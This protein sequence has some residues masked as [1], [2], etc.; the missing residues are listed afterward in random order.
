[1]RWS[2]IVIAVVLAVGCSSS[3]SLPA[4]AP[5]PQVGV[6]QFTGEW[7]GSYRGQTFKRDGPLSIV[8][9]TADSTAGVADKVPIQG[10]VRFGGVPRDTR[11]GA[12]PLSAEERRNAH[13]QTVPIDSARLTA[14]GIVMW[15]QSYF[16]SGCNCTISLTTRAVLRGDTLAGTFSAA[17]GPTRVSER[18]R[19]RAVRQRSP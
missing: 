10:R 1:M 13:E 5:G 18:G 7:I 14:N 2:A 3:P 9:E 15:L 16:D 8:I 6:S 12:F 11:D 17:Q 19:W 4:A